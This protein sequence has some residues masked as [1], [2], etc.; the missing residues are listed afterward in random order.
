MY[1]RKPHPDF[2]DCECM[3]NYIH[4]RTEKE[5][6]DCGAKADDQ[7]DSH[8]NEINPEEKHWRGNTAHQERHADSDNDGQDD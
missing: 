2:W 7:P 6:K 8:D 4:Y 1:R 5:C 3:N